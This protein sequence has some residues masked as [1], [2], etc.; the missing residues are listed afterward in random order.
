[1]SNEPNIKKYPHL[2]PNLEDWPIYK[3]SQDRDSFIKK[4]SN[5]VIQFFSKYSP[6]DLDQTLPKRHIFVV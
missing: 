4:V 5:D 1:M 3:F 6:E 2:L